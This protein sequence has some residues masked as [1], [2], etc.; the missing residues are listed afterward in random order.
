MSENTETFKLPL[1][2]HLETD[3]S[4][5]AVQGEK[6][7]GRTDGIFN[8]FLRRIF[9]MIKIINQSRMMQTAVSAVPAQ[10]VL[11]TFLLEWYVHV[12]VVP[13]QILSPPPQKKKQSICTFLFIH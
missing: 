4:V 6:R 9:F 12:D 7:T 10:R 1:Q 3:L 8:V 5:D 11:R 2:Q 13:T